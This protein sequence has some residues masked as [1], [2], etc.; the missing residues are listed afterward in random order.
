[1]SK[2]LQGNGQ[3]ESSRMM[4]FEHRDRLNEKGRTWHKKTRPVLDEQELEEIIHAIGMSMWQSLPITLVL[5]G[6]FEDREIVGIAAKINQ[7]NRLVKLIGMNYTE[8]IP[9]DD[10][11]K[12]VT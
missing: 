7:E 9:I 12:A 2:K 3:F 1:V 6:E 11:L 8:W 4:L 5:W 10:I